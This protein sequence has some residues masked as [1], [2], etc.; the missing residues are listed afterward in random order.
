[1]SDC[2]C[3]REIAWYLSPSLPPPSFSP[4]LSRSLSI[5]IHTYVLHTC[6]KQKLLVE[7]R[8]CLS[9]CIRYAGVRQLGQVRYIC[10]LIL[11]CVCAMCDR[12]SGISSCHKPVQAHHNTQAHVVTQ[13]AGSAGSSASINLVIKAAAKA[14]ADVLAV[15]LGPSVKSLVSVGDPSLVVPRVAA[16]TGIDFIRPQVYLLAPANM[17][18]YVCVYVCKVAVILSEV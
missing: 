7:E 6:T 5:Y 12:D 17:Y 1:M 3:E 13:L 18:K 8:V 11:L 9:S 10:V 14:P 4:A 15:N 2:V 16:A